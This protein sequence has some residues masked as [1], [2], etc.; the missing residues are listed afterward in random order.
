[1]LVIVLCSLLLEATAKASASHGPQLGCSGG[2][3]REES[4]TLQPA[5]DLGCPGVSLYIHNK[6][7]PHVDTI[8]S[9]RRGLIYRPLSI[10]HKCLICIA[11]VCYVCGSN[12]PGDRL[13]Y[14]YRA[15]P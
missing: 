13:M 4:A 11:Q 15:N 8:M 3:G 1:M 12:K 10:L 9:G 7:V 6:S 5:T 2:K 14:A